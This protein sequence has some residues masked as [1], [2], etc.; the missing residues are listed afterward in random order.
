MSLTLLLFTTTRIS[1][2]QASRTLAGFLT[3]FVLGVVLYPAL[4]TV[5]AR[6][7]AG[8]QLQTYGIK[9][10]E[11]KAGTP[12]MGGLLFVVL[13]VVAYGFYDH[14]R[15]GFIAIFALTCGAGLGFLDDLA[16][17]RGAGALGLRGRQ[18]LALQAVIGVL[19]G[20]GLN[21]VGQTRELLPGFG[22]VDLH[23]GIVVLAALAIVAASN[24]VNLT[25]GVD[26]L[27]ASTAVIVFATLWAIAVREQQ[28]SPGVLSAALVGGLL[29]FLIFNWWPARVFMG[30][31]GSMALG[32]IVVV[33]AAEVRLLWLLPL[34]GVVF[35]A[36]TLSVIINVTAIRRFHRRVFRA[37]PLHHHF[38]ILG[39]REQRLVL[40]FTGAQAMG[41]LLTFLVALPAVNHK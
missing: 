6:F 12:T 27:A 37:S 29:A 28:R 5:L 21:Q 39:L 34:L 32:C 38:E 18:K 17:V 35:V 11:V 9:T 8:Q 22:L 3:A 16:N 40:C 1:A 20:A 36:E 4:I 24:A 10:H 23:W 2:S 30:D 13:A 19:V 31:T 25:D 15:S 7:N 14:S 26:G 41:A 33:L